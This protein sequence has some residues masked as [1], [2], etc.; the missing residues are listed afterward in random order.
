[1]KKKI[2]L[3]CLPFAGGNKY[4]YREFVEKAP[5]FLNIITLE[6]PGRGARIKEPL[7]ADI[8]SLVDNL[9]SQVSSDINNDINYGIYGHSM[10]GL[11]CYLLTLKIL[12]NKKQAPRHLFITGTSGPSSPSRKEEKKRYLLDRKEFIEEI[13][14][15]DGM[16]EEILQND[17]LLYYF[18]PILR[19]DFKLSE[20][21]IYQH[22]NPLNIPFT[23]ITGS[24]EDMEHE[25]IQSWQKESTH[26]VDFKKL[27]GKH[28]FIFKHT[29]TIVDIIS[30]KL[31]V[32]TK[33]YQYE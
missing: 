1:M 20:N 23:V 14:A 13:K 25:E 16:P 15:L 27:P 4:S 10:G 26:K 3:Y 19:S 5:S 24:E 18:E 11:L 7:L 17:E 21:Y 32:Q 30:K 33:A 12:G 22:H 6:Y 28:F 8:N 31:F 2:N 29:Q 9:Y